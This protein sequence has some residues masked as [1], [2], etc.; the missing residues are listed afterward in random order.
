MMSEDHEREESFEGELVAGDD[1]V[2]LRALKV[3]AFALAAILALVAVVFFLLRPE[4]AEDKVDEKPLVLPKVQDVQATA[5]QVACS[6]V[7]AAAGIDFVHFNGATGEKLLPETMGPGCAFFD[8]DLDG[9][10]ELLLVNA[11]SWPGDAPGDPAPTLRLYSNDGKGSFKDVTAVSGLAVTVYGM[12]AAVGDYDNDGKPDLFITTVN[13]N[14]LFRNL[15]GRFEDVTAAA[16]VAGGNSTWSSSAGFFDCDNDGDLDLFVCNYI[17]WSRKIDTALDYRLT[18]VGRAYGPPTNF[19]G[20]Q[21]YFY[22][23]NGDGTFVESAEKAGLQVL[24]RATGKPV[25]KAL[26]LIPFAV[27]YVALR[28]RGWLFL[29]LLA[30]VVLGGAL[31]HGFA[32]LEG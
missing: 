17:S 30:L 26:A 22:R 19:E 18:G 24:N 10:Q 11:M 20:T 5:P 9:D 6:D 8:F 1:T 27:V 21:P 28:A 7:T 12:G 32:L 31:Q 2:I 16:G 4:Q 3:S 29:R 23:N 25:A 14:R 15:G 13:E